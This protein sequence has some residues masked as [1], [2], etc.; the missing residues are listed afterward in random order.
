[1]LGLGDVLAARLLYQRAAAL[2]SARG[3]TAVGKTYDPA[4][5]AAIGA[6]GVTADR[7]AAAVWYRGGAALGDQDGARRLAGLAAAK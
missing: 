2:G 6:S 4:I 5:L 3:A 7:A 1:M